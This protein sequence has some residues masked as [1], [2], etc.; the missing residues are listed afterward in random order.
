MSTRELAAS[1]TR[2][3][4]LPEV[5]DWIITGAAWDAAKHLLKRTRA[6]WRRR[7]HRGPSVEFAD[8][9]GVSISRKVI[10]PEDPLVTHD[11]PE[12]PVNPTL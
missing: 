9:I 1:K 6:L 10:R 5:L 7:R 3:E 8:T 2:F 4:G 12:P 11:A